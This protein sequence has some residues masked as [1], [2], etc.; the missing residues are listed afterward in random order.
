MSDYDRWL[1]PPSTRG[2]EKDETRVVNC[3]N[4]GFNDDVEGTLYREDYNAT[5]YAECPRCGA[6]LEVDLDL[7]GE[8]DQDYADAHEDREW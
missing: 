1:E 6:E 8:A 5:F 7:A 2:T 3:G 4:C